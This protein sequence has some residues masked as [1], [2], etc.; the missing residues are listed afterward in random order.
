MLFV[1]IGVL[2]FVWTGLHFG[3]LYD[4]W[5]YAGTIIVI[6]VFTLCISKCIILGPG[7]RGSLSRAFTIGERL[8]ARALIQQKSPCTP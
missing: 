5:T 6:N 2:L 7:A 4:V 1:F 3:I 8:E